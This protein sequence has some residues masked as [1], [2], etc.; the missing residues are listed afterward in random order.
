MRRSNAV[1]MQQDVQQTCLC[2][3]YYEG[4]CLFSVPVV[5]PLSHISARVIAGSSSIRWV[6]SSYN[7]TVGSKSSFLYTRSRR[8]IRNSVISFETSCSSPSNRRSR[9][10]DCLSCHR[11][12]QA[13][14]IARKKSRLGAHR[15]WS[16]SFGAFRHRFRASLYVRQAMLA[17]AVSRRCIPSPSRCFQPLT[18]SLPGRVARTSFAYNSIM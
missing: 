3:D 2:I 1:L 17:A 11:C 15:A 12:S 9:D 14:V 16:S 13:R 8:G 18:H 10:P 5:S 6:S 4:V 7:W